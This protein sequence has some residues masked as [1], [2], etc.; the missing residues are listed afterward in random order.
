MLF[1][2]KTDEEYGVRYYDKF[3]EYHETQTLYQTV[4]LPGK[5]TLA[6]IATKGSPESYRN[7][8]D[9]PFDSIKAIDGLRAG[10][11]SARSDEKAGPSGERGG[12]PARM[13]SSSNPVE[14]SHD[15]KSDDE[16]IVKFDV[17][18]GSSQPEEEGPDKAQGIQK[19][20]T[21]Y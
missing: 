9:I 6:V 17:K 16:T 2:F 21:G 1:S 5:N 18:A 12:E 8:S 15:L 10:N 14:Q 13:Q 3:A 7:Y 4:H 20:E 11:L 19:C